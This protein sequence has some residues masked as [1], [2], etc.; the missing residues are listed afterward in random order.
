MLTRDPN[1]LLLF[2]SVRESIVCVEAMKS[3]WFESGKAHL[4]RIRKAMA[5]GDQIREVR[6]STAENAPRCVGH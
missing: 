4:G 6:T 3:C 2:I 1:K 5:P